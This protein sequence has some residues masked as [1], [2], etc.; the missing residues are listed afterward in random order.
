M[1]SNS[2]RAKMAM[3]RYGDEICWESDD[4]RLHKGTAEGWSSMGGLQLIV[5]GARIALARVVSRYRRA[6]ADAGRIEWPARRQERAH[7]L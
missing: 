4:A 7:T 5:D 3:I 1:L 6:G 2:D